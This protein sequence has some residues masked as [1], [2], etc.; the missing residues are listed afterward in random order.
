MQVSLDT[1]LLLNEN[2]FRIKDLHRL[3]IMQVSRYF[4]DGIVW[5]FSMPNLFLLN[6]LHLNINTWHDSLQ[7]L[8]DEQQALQLAFTSLEEKF[9]KMQEDNNDL[10][11]R[12]MALKAKD[13][14]RMNTENDQLIKAKQKKL[15]QQ[16][17]EAAKEHKEITPPKYV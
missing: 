15:Q 14:D 4:G 1:L 17:E 11:T 13:A 6:K 2:Y 7:V 9:R 12:W 3:Y 5:H 8:A 10:V 16:L